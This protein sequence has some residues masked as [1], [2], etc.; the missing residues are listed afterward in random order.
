MCIGPEEKIQL[1][2]IQKTSSCK[3]IITKLNLNL[4][5]YKIL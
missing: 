2:K 5:N 4:K 1:K 3:H